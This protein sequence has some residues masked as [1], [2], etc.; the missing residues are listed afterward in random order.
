MVRKLYKHELSALGRVLI[1]MELL[2]LI[3]AVLVRLIQ[4]FE[5]D[6]LVYKIIFGSSVFF[7][8]VVNLINLSLPL[9]MGVIRFYRNLF[10]GEGY[11]SF[12]LPVTPLAH[13]F[14]KSAAALTFAAVNTV[15]CLTSV[16]IATLGEVFAEILL[17]LRYLLDLLTAFAGSH[18]V[19]FIAELVLLFAAT[20]CC[21]LLLFY[22]CICIGQLFRKNRVLAACGV[23]FVY[24]VFVQILSTVF[25]VVFGL[26]VDAPLMEQLAA[27]TEKNPVLTIHLVLAGSLLL[28]LIAGAIWFVI[29]HTIIRKKLNLE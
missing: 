18:T 20:F 14:V 10:T 13:L 25:S 11:L 2:L 1:P 21:E 24:Y 8:A 6:H 28:S 29:S 9:V 5:S 3:V 15:L 4:L 23:Y 27:F 7:L 22:T 12:T 26:F 16:G 19:L 17:A